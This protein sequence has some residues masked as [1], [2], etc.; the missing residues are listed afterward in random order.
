MKL[1]NTIKKSVNLAQN[2]GICYILFRVYFE[3]QKRT[4]LL[5]K[6]FP[7]NPPFK[8]FISLEEWKNKQPEFFFRSRKT[9]NFP[10]KQNPTL[11]EK[12]EKIK[13][14]KFLFFSSLEFDLNNISWFTN[15]STGY[16][17]SQD[18]HWTE[19]E[20]LS[21]QAGDI[22]YV[23]DRARF[24]YLY[25]IIRY[26]YH[27]EEDNSSFVFGLIEDFIN[28]NPINT[29]PN[30]V[31]SQETSLRIL[32]WTFALYFYQ[33]SPA[34]TSDRFIKIINSIYWQLDH[35]YKNINFSRITVRN[36]HAI[37]ETMMLFLS[38]MLFPFFPESKQ[39]QAKGR[40]W[41]EKEIEYQ[42]Y[43]DGS[44]LQFSHN[45]HRVVLQLLTWAISLSEIHETK[46]SK[47]VY[48]KAKKTLNFLFDHLDNKSGCLPNYGMNDGALFFPL[49][50]QHYRDFRPQLQALSLLLDKKLFK[51]DY[52][53]QFWFG[54][55]QE[56][57]KTHKNPQQHTIIKYPTG[58]FFGFRDNALTT[59]RCGTYKDRPAQADALNLDI[60]IDGVNYITDPGTYRY[61]TEEPLIK[62]YFGSTGHNTIT[63]GDYDQML[64]GGR[65]I[66][67]YWTQA[68]KQEIKEYDDFFEFDGMIKCFPQLGK[69]IHHQRKVIKYKNQFKWII[70]DTVNYSGNVKKVLRWNL[71]PGYEK[72][73]MIKCTG[74]GGKFIDRLDKKNGIPNA[75]E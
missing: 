31:C 16:S 40:S 72:S 59:I 46:L 62:F 43:D 22:K 23:W 33:D 49:N 60:W 1:F 56:S 9:L 27:F 4:G 57:Q 26:D 3:L 32:N 5:R 15:P 10:K 65:F 52:E 37:T 17:Y 53:D 25:D 41:L 24:C 8:E 14:G 54:L 58:G 66:W 28:N 55:R 47:A 44:Y 67:Y 39:W 34:L 64:K 51:T 35:I 19:I 70:T 69:N 71:L 6:K 63:L 68:M 12:T 75:M 18:A 61:N 29:G 7:V 30:Y 48:E 50:D 42:I 2:M 45:Y 21:E 11:K 73:I 38:G 74:A 13:N 36:N 20:S